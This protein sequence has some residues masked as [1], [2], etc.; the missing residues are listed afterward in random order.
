MTFSV[1][2]IGAALEEMTERR[3]VRTAEEF[4]RAVSEVCSAASKRVVAAFAGD[5]RARSFMGAGLL[6]VIDDNELDHWARLLSVRMTADAE[7]VVW[8]LMA[9][10]E[11]AARRG[12]GGK[13]QKSAELALVD[14]RDVAP[15]QD[16]ASVRGR[17]ERAA[18]ALCVAAG[19]DEALTAALINQVIAEERDTLVTASKLERLQ[20]SFYATALVLAYFLDCVSKRSNA[21][22]GDLAA[23]SSFASDTFIG[24]QPADGTWNSFYLDGGD[25]LPFTDQAVSAVKNLVGESHPLG[26]IIDALVV[27]ATK[28]AAA[29]EEEWPD[30]ADVRSARIAEAQQAAPVPERVWAMRN[31]AGATIAC[32]CHVVRL[33][34]LAA[35]VATLAVTGARTQ[36]V[37]LLTQ[38]IALKAE[39]L[40]SETHPGLLDELCDL[41]DVLGEPSAVADVAGASGWWCASLTSDTSFARAA[42]ILCI[43]EAV[44]HARDSDG[45][46]QEAIEIL[47]AAAAE[48][49]TAPTDVAERLKTRA[50]ALGSDGHSPSRAGVVRALAAASAPQLEVR[51]T[52]KR[53]L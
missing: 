36:A 34:R 27:Q 16:E 1:R 52:S 21:D 10:A 4:R 14:A 13:A 18:D 30:E 40:G 25:R 50:A 12:R 49:G 26:K 8:R 3:E 47:E 15:P 7:A 41:H 39:W 6:N 23:C 24:M 42:R 51:R 33:T 29:P 11:V 43:C 35:C 45:R 17:V 44:A 37:E 28:L 48:Y 19:A 38:A 31:A 46:T 20:A 5:A 53:P 32:V 9:E 22:P 2:V